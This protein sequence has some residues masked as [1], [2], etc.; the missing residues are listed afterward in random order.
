[1]DAR[2]AE[3][4]G[5][6]KRMS[7]TERTVYVNGSYCRE[8]EARVSIFDRG[9]LFADAVYEVTCVLGGR[10][11]D[12]QGHMA[13]LRRSLNE[14]GIPSPLGE[15]DILGA[16]RRL[17]EINEIDEGL[18]YT[19]VTRGEADRDFNF[20]PKE[21]KPTL[22]MFNQTKS[23]TENPAAHRGLSVISVPDIRW[24]RRDIKTVQ[25]LYSSMAKH[26][27]AET[28]ADDAWLVQDGFV[29]E[30]SSANAYIITM[31]RKIVTRGLSNDILH[32]ITRSAVLGFVEESGFTLE[33][34]AFTIEEAKS[35]REAF[36][37]SATSLVMPV[38]RID[39][40]PVDDGK[41]GPATRR[42]RQIYI[43]R[44]LATSI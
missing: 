21:T 31:D 18:I 33:E 42:L 39:G 13:R 3:R 7:K 24:G 8:S 26:K 34:R 40:A 9:F 17:V 14:L 43:E 2:W 41:V 28:G 37:T 20:P 16:H 27:A 15:D 12:F 29:T 5:K 6:R 19:Q 23:V 4:E 32:G 1:M 10:L 25:L 11:V 36:C 44:A 35:A 22:I 30:A 38:V